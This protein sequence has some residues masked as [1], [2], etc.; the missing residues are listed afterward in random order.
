[1]DHRA[2]QFQIA[3]ADYDHCD[4]V[5]DRGNQLL[6]KGR[7]VLSPDLGKDPRLGGADQLVGAFDDGAAPLQV[8]DLAAGLG[9]VGVDGQGVLG[10]VQ[11]VVELGAQP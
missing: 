7:D 6:V 9:G 4:S 8:P 5:G 2:R 1:M 3:I 11:V 10:G